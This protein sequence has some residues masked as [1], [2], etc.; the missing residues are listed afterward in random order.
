MLEQE[1][2][3]L[4]SLME[5]VEKYGEWVSRRKSPSKKCDA[6]KQ[7]VPGSP[8][9][10]CRATNRG[11]DRISKLRHN[12]CNFLRSARQRVNEPSPGSPLHELAE[13][14]SP[15]PKGRRLL[16]SYAPSKSYPETLIT[17]E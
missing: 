4:V 10:V 17:R 3:G 1:K 8:R 6:V 13:Y 12:P 7:A 15:R 2:G 9:V 5:V 16:C 11:R 14:L